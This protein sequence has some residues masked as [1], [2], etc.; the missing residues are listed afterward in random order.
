MGRARSVGALVLVLAL[1]AILLVTLP[2]AAPPPAPMRTQ[3]RAFDSGGS[4]LAIGTPIRTFVDGVAYSNNSLVQNGAGSYFVLTSGNS[5]GAGGVSDTP[6]IQEGA[7]LGD[8]VI[9]AAGDFT[10]ATGVFREVRTWS[11][12]NVTIMDLTL[13]TNPTLPQ[14]MKIEGLITQPAAV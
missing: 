5:K 2:V 3:G 10:S 11:V 6:T 4:P 12:A 1:A 13:G 14:P 8:S 9:F 7:N